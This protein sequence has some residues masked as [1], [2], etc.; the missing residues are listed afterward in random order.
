MT[1]PVQHSERIDA[2]GRLDADDWVILPPGQLQGRGKP[3]AA[4]AE[5]MARLYFETV[6]RASAIPLHIERQAQA[7]H[8]LAPLGKTALILA[9]PEQTV[10]DRRAETSWSI[11][12]GFLL[13]HKVNYG[14][15]FYLGAEAQSDGGIK[16]YSI[17]RRFP[18]RLTPYIGIP[19]G[20]ALYRR[21][22]GSTIRGIQTQFLQVLAARLTAHPHPEE[23]R[24]A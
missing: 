7:V 17:L 10:D 4:L 9:D 5:E 13:A 22:P 24:L 2:Q 18:P 3:D 12:G 11:A 21:I 14:G 1:F 20:F 6:R 16:L 15:R 19:R 8:I 23:Q